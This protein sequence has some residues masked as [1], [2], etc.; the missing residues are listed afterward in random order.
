MRTI[1]TFGLLVTALA[2]LLPSAVAAQSNIKIRGVRPEVH[3]TIG[4]HGAIG[5]GARADIPVVPDGFIRGV[6]DEFVLSPGGELLIDLDDDFDNDQFDGDDDLY[7][8]G[9]FAPQWNFYVSPEW[10]LF[11]ELG[12][13]LIFGDF[14]RGRDDDLEM[15]LRLLFSLGARYHFSS[16]NALL[17]RLTWPYGL[18]VGVTF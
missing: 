7:I 9:V 12:L 5:V 2:T 6:D 11:P 3:G 13:T 17:M 8:A 16:R 15:R 1:L 4:W 10:S 18:Q 14:D